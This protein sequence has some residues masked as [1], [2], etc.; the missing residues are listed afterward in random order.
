MLLPYQIQVDWWD[1]TTTYAWQ[2]GWFDVWVCDGG[3]GGSTGGG[4]GGG[5]GGTP[6]PSQP[7]PP[8]LSLSEVSDAN[9][10]QPLLHIIENDSVVETTL[11]YNGNVVS[12]TGKT[13]VLFLQPLDALSGTTT[14]TVQAKNSAN[15]YA[16]ALFHIDRSFAGPFT[17]STNVWAVWT[18]IKNGEPD[19]VQ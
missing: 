9:P 6:P 8:Y 16:T 14:V 7:E 12:T 15:V 3:G 18:I 4:G 11:A 13:D 17:G 10:S 1:G 19:Q 5:G 2:F